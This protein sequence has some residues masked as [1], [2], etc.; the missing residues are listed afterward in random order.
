MKGHKMNLQGFNLWEK[1]V[2][3]IYQHKFNF[4]EIQHFEECE[5]EVTENVVFTGVHNGTIKVAPNYYFIHRGEINGSLIVEKGARV[6][7]FGK[8]KGSIVVKDLLDIRKTSQIEGQVEASKLFIQPGAIF[9][10]TT[11]LKNEIKGVK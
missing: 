6:T 3:K 5:V 2:I 4:K 11:E 8:V 10:C 1:F 9:N 7:I